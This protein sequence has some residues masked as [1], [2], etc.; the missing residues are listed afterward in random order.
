MTRL[1]DISYIFKTFISI[2]Q[3]TWRTTEKCLI[4]TVHGMSSLNLSSGTQEIERPHVEFVS[5]LQWLLPGSWV[6][7]AE[8]RNLLLRFNPFV[9]TNVL[10]ISY[11]RSKYYF[12]KAEYVLQTQHSD[13]EE[14]FLYNSFL[15]CK[16][17]FK[18]KKSSKIIAYLSTQSDRREQ[19]LEAGASWPPTAYK[20]PL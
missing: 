15:E 20:N 12:K 9:I 11:R 17:K 14:N 6:A 3:I 10:E 5:L 16:K 2:S 1:C 13:C 4:R 7:Q 19:W 18:K 8:G